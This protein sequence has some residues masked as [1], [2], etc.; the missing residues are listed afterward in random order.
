MSPISVSSV[1]FSSFPEGFGTLAVVLAVGAIF[2]AIDTATVVA[3]VQVASV[4]WLVALLVVEMAAS[5]RFMI[6]KIMNHPYTSVPNA[7]TKMM[8][9]M[10]QPYGVTR[11]PMGKAE[12]M[13]SVNFLLLLSHYS[14]LSYGSVALLLFLSF[15]TWKE[16]CAYLE[17]SRL[18]IQC[19]MEYQGVVSKGISIACCI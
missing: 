6:I 3:A 19:Q 7:G 11:V 13:S 5:W 10:S 8:M 12:D 16:L 15:H 1:T 17:T 9:G 4:A 18:I 2:F 14:I